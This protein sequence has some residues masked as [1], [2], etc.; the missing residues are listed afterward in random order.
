[1]F[2]SNE[3]RNSCTSTNNAIQLIDNDENVTV[4]RVTAMD[5]HFWSVSRQK[6]VAINDACQQAIEALCNVSFR[7]AK[8]KT[9]LVIAGQRLA[10]VRVQRSIRRCPSLDEEDLT[11]S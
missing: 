7:L 5:K 6:N 2:L 11:S 9:C 10:L 3:R 8:G 4:V 1:M